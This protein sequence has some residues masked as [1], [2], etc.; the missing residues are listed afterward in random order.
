[1]SIACSWLMP[2]MWALVELHRDA[3]GDRRHDGQLVGGVHAF[4]VEGRVGF[5]IAQFLRLLQHGGEVQALVAHLGQDE[6]GGA[7]DDAGHRFDAVGRQA[8]AQR[9]DDR[10]AAGH[11]RLE[12]HHHALFLGGGED[13]VAVQGQQALLAVTTC[14]PLAIACSTSSRGSS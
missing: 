5:G 11:G 12:G 2:S 3:E 1:M 10:H 9:L 8:F 14:L 6:V 7:V 13:L 4:D